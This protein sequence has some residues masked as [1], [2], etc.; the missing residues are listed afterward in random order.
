MD[1][2]Y[3]ALMKNNI[4][5]LVNAP[6]NKNIVGCRWTYKLK[7]NPDGSI[8][9]YKARLVA[10][11]YSQQFGSDFNETFSSVVKPTT[12]R[13]IMTIALSNHWKIRQIDVNNAF[14]NGELKEEVYMHQPKGI[15]MMKVKILCVNYTRLYMD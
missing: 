10:K 3:P 6:T 5:T 7:K 2:E 4:W 8:S 13:I 15:L 12:I 11:G 1:T 9:K 14:L